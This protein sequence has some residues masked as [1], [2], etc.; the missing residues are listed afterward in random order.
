MA[1][2]KRKNGTGTCIK[3]PDG[4]Y[5]A[6]V[7]S[8]I[9]NQKTFKPKRFK[10]VANT[11]QE[12]L[13]GAL[14]KKDAWEKEYIN[15]GNDLKID[16]SKTFGKYLE[17]YIDTQVKG[18]V[19]SSTYYTYIRNMRF[20]FYNH[21][22]AVLQ[23]HMLSQKVFQDYYDEIGAKYSKKTCSFPIQ[24][25]RRVCQDLVDKSLLKEN[26]AKQAAPKKEV[27]DDY[28]KAQEERDKNHKEIFSESDIKKFYEAYKRHQGEYAR[29]VIF[30]LE[31]GLR[32]SE[33]ASLCNSDIDL[34]NNILIVNKSRAYRLKENSKKEIEEYVK[35]PKNG[36]E[37]KVHLS[38]LAKEV[39]LEMQEQ[40]KIYSP[41]NPDDLLY[42][43]FYSQGKR[44]SN[45]S[46]EVCFK[47]LCDKLGIDRDVHLTK[48]GNQKG[49]CLHSLRHTMNS[50]SKAQNRA[51]IAS[52]LGHSLKVNE[53]VYTHTNEDILQEIKTPSQT[54]LEKKDEN[55]DLD[56]TEEQEKLLLKKL[57]KKYQNEE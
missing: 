2:T 10:K 30:L 19:T 46:M 1:N 56:L 38:P 32:I 51:S 24:L 8:S 4:K 50:F 13:E 20:L 42:P 36:K 40:T 47:D 18:S 21:N 23:L 54:V 3:R 48:R 34:E 29:V 15:H 45:S 26:Y 25:C 53:E 9:I 43:S 44:R 57:L 5:E 17:E 16:K 33:F 41:Y 28:L 35:V 39:I 27:L 7:Q 31:T 22:I 49:L 12:A 37:R 14:M 55:L 11:E 6:I 52:M